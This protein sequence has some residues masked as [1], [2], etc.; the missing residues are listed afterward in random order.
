MQFSYSEKNEKETQSEKPQNKAEYIQGQFERI[1]SAAAYLRLE[2]PTEPYETSRLPTAENNA[3]AE[4]ICSAVF[5]LHEREIAE[6]NERQKLEDALNE[7]KAFANLNAPFSELDQLSYLTLRVGHLDPKG[8]EEIKKNLADRAAIIPLDDG[9][10]LAASSRNGRFA[11]DSELKKQAFTPIAIPKDYKGIPV[12]LLSGLE[13]RYKNTETDLQK[14]SEEK[15]H[16][17]AV[18]GHQLLSLF[19]S[20]LMANITEQLKEKLVATASTYFLAGWIP[21]TD[22]NNFAAELIRLTAGR[23]GIRT[24]EPS[25]VSSVRSGA[26]KVPT[27]LSHGRFVRSFEPLVFSYGAPLYGS[28]DP[29]PFVAVFFTLLF[30]VM[31]GDVGQG[32]VLLLLGLLINQKKVKFLAGFEHFGG[33][34]ISVGIFSMIMGLLYG[35]IFSNETLLE[36]PTRAFTGFLTETPVGNFFGIHETEKIL[37]LMPERGSLTKLFYFFGFTLALGVILNSV[38]LIFNIINQYSSKNYEKAFF[39]KTG[40]AGALLFWYAIGIAIRFIFQGT[41]HWFDVPCLVIPLLCIFFGPG[42]WRLIAGEHPLLK[43]GLLVFIME[44][45]VEILETLSSYISNSVS[46]LRV[47][48]FALSHAVLSFITFTMADLVAK[49]SMLGPLF[50]VVVI[51]FGNLIIIVLEGMIVAIQVTRL[52]YYEFFSKFFTETGVRFVPFRFRKE[53]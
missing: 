37:S 34:L 20:Y 2:L 6:K 35:G 17:L 14:I 48:A 1:K 21:A 33:P 23:I 22:A 50:S 47:G 32:F 28:I 40:L 44:G 5:A 53:N 24:L 27:S 13:T 52:Q 30:G 26:E 41:L 8:Q 36:A 16:L 39:S 42:I 15:D 3:L 43:E 49:G 31:F 12:E 51:I 9:R 11:L 18:Y 45:I 4:T 29:T 10:I 46:F 38:G 19:A 7:S 25:E